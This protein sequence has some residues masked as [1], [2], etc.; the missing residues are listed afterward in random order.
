MRRAAAERMAE[1]ARML[2]Y[3]FKVTAKEE[4]KNL[5]EKSGH[6]IWVILRGPGNFD[7]VC[8]LKEYS[9]MVDSEPFV[10]KK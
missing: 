1:R 5:F 10:Y 6:V 2:E 4:K 7:D 3:I 8:G 9:Q